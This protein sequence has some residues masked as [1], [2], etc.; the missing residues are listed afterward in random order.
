[1]GNFIS[2]KDVYDE[3]VKNG[4]RLGKDLNRIE[5]R[6]YSESGDSGMV[7]VVNFIREYDL[8]SG[9]LFTIHTLYDGLFDSII[10]TFAYDWVGNFESDIE[11]LLDEG[12]SLREIPFEDYELTEEM[13]VALEKYR[14]IEDVIV[15]NRVAEFIA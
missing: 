14:K 11:C 7:A 8:Y 15:Q 3:Y 4:Y 9:S 6:E 2:I 12:V 13:V 1:M 5:V 10:D